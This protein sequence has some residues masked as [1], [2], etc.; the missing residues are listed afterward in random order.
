MFTVLILLSC[1]NHFRCVK[2]LC[3]LFLPSQRCCVHPV[4]LLLP[5]NWQSYSFRKCKI[6]G[7]FCLR[8]SVD[9]CYRKQKDRVQKRPALIDVLSAS[10]ELVWNCACTCVVVYHDIYVEGFKSCSWIKWWKLKSTLQLYCKNRFWQ[11]CVPPHFF[12]DDRSCRFI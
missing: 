1:S 12:A 5:L 10:K 3:G 7:C 6:G 2:C 8:F 9:T 11:L 4:H